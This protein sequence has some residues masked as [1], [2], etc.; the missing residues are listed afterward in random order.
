M[1]TLGFFYTV[2]YLLLFLCLLIISFFNLPIQLLTNLSASTFFVYLY[3]YS[4]FRFLFLFLIFCLTGLPP[5]GFFLIKFNIFCFVLY[6]THVISAIILFL[7]FFFNMIFYIQFFTFKNNKL[8]LYST[9]NTKHLSF[10]HDDRTRALQF[11]T[12]NSYNLIL[13][14][15]NVS[16]VLVSMILIFNDYFFILNLL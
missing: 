5:V 2:V 1:F 16:F 12:Y 8:N 7:L 10:W 15:V 4:I 14:I 6:Q 3:K 11:T 13:F 9:V